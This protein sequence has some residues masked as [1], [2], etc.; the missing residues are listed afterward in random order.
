M[1]SF[2]KGKKVLITGAEGFIG[3]H[4]TEEL[5]KDGA[6]ARAFIFYNSFGKRGWL[7]DMPSDFLKGTEILYGDIRDPNK[8]T[9]AVNGMDIVFHLASLISIPYSYE[10]PDSYASTNVGGT[11]NLLNACR[12]EKTQRI[13]HTSTSEVYGTAQY[14]P[15]DE[16]HPLQPQSPYSASKIAADS[17]ALS[18]YY[19]FNLP[20]AI[21]RPFNTFGPRQST[22]A[23]I[24]AIIAQIYSG[25]DI[26]ELGDTTPTRDFNYVKNTVNAF[27]KVAEAK[28]AEGEVF[29]AGSEREISIKDLVEL[30]MKIT[31]KKVKVAVKQERIRPQ[32]SE[33]KRLLCDSTKIRQKCGWNPQVSLEEGLEITAKWIKDNLAAYKL[34]TYSV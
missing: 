20:V 30:I 24:P 9:E 27:M 10:A 12:I 28:D 26:I 16:K 4:L 14:V 32:N 6:K 33:I 29:N 21:L 34:S 2:W 11:L 3:S 22:R 23:V 17:F 7:E 25:Q 8:V 13:I 18:Y 5:I 19:S 15:I 1:S 31:G